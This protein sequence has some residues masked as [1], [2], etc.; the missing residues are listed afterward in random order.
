MARKERDQDQGQDQSHKMQ[1]F[2]L[3]T[4]VIAVVASLAWMA[5]RAK[6]RW[7]TQRQR[8]TLPAAGAAA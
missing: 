8:R 5:V 1:F 7:Q 2:G 3:S 4:A 6:G